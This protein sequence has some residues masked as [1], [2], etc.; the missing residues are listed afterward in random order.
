MSLPA[1][2]ESLSF[3]E[4]F[5]IVLNKPENIKPTAIFIFNAYNLRSKILKWLNWLDNDLYFVSV[6]LIGWEL[7]GAVVSMSV[8]DQQYG[9]MAENSAVTVP[10]ITPVS[11]VRLS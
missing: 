2:F 1:N 9:V 5:K 6:K 7:P 4:K 11:H 8:A 3:Q 10:N